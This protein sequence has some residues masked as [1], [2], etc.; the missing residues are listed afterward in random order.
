MQ[1][2]IGV[3]ILAF[4]AAM[5]AAFGL[6]LGRKLWPEARRLAHRCIPAWRRGRAD[7]LIAREQ[8]VDA[9]GGGLT[10]LSYRTGN[11][12]CFNTTPN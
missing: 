6:L 10:S 5:L 3:L 11:V 12:P 4:N 1:G 9:S 8:K 7:Y 2:L